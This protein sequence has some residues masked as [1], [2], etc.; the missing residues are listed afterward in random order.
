MPRFAVKLLMERFYGICSGVNGR[1][2]TL[3]SNLLL[4]LYLLTHI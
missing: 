2:R 1:L 4:S 3:F